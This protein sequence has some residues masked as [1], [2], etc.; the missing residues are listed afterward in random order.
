MKLKLPEFLKQNLFKLPSTKRKEAEVKRLKEE[1]YIKAE[2]AR[3]ERAAKQRQQMEEYYEETRK[4][5]ER[6][7][8]LVVD[9]W[10]PSYTGVI[11]PRSDPEDVK[12]TLE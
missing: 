11:L 2:E 5:R 4:R 7:N 6:G 1:A 3:Q 10:N 9:D 12:I 8:Y